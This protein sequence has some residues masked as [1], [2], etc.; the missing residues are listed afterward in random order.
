MSR[1]NLRPAPRPSTRLGGQPPVQR[2][3]RSGLRSAG[4]ALP[5]LSELCSQPHRRRRAPARTAAARRASPAAPSV[6]AQVSAATFSGL[7]DAPPAGHSSAASSQAEQQQEVPAASSVADRSEPDTGGDD[8]H[9]E[10]AQQLQDLAEP[11]TDAVPDSL[12]ADAPELREPEASDPLPSTSDQAGQQQE[13]FMA[14]LSEGI[15]QEEDWDFHIPVQ[16]AE[17]E[18][19]PEPEPETD[20]EDPWTAEDVAEADEML[21]QLLEGPDSEA[22]SQAA[23]RFPAPGPTTF[24]TQE[25]GLFAYWTS[26]CTLPAPPHPQAFPGAHT[27]IFAPWTSS[28]HAGGGGQH[29]PFSRSPLARESPTFL[30]RACGSPAHRS[31]PRRPAGSRRVSLGEMHRPVARDHPAGPAPHPA[32]SLAGHSMYRH[33]MMH[34]A[35]A[36]WRQEYLPQQFPPHQHPPW[37]GVDLFPRVL[38]GGGTLEEAGGWDLHGWPLVLRP[39]V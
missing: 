16:A 22:E 17:P 8:S 3:R 29:T 15:A 35:V 28:T 10:Q 18:P 5:S 23:V 21:R 33:L 19:E 31:P 12:D 7:D 11:T 1:Y 25:G 34:Q 32:R 24:P 39:R 6:T 30:C 27:C 20:A 13:S 2:A 4:D 26:D 37:G 38:T 9:T 14:L 36:A